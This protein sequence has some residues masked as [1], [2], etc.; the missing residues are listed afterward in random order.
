MKKKEINISDIIAF[1]GDMLICVHGNSQ[2]V[3]IDNFADM[4]HVTEHTLDWINKN[5]LNKQE[6]AENTVAKVIIA[7]PQVLYSK[8]LN[9]DGKVLITVANPR[10]AIAMIIEEFFVDKDK[11]GIHPHSTIHP[12]AIIDNTATI[13]PGCV[14]GKV[15]IGKNTIL[16]P[17]VVLYDDVVLGDNCLIQ[18]GAVIG[19]DGLGCMREKDGKLRKFP[20]I[21]G[22][23]IG[24]DVE[25]GANC[26][27]A[28]GVLSDTIIKNGCKINGMCFIAHNCVLE[29]N[30]WITGDTMLCG[31]V[32]VGKNVTI[33]SNVIVRDQRNIGERATIGMGSVVTK[34]I[35]VG[36]TWVGNPARKLSK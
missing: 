23:V 28:K 6:F 16:K 14:I 31:T 24:N 34:D 26:Q 1:L 35:P 2:N 19:T 15:T 21:G 27:I 8:K 7:D 3:C 36:E 33:F 5:K 29:E 30:V 17:N 10:L 22:V 20:H 12:D 4:E 18:A 13:G 25:I 32:H 11:V 9:E